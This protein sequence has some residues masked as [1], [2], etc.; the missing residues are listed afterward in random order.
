MI[1]SI[2][3][4]EV[5]DLLVLGYQFTEISEKLDI[6]VSTAKYRVRRFCRLMNARNVT[7]AAVLYDRMARKGAR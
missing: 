6:P 1:L 5:L 4:R 7:Q 2:K 3:E